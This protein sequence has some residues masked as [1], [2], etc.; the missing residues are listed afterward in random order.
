M[1]GRKER[2]IAVRYCSAEK[3][4]VSNIHRLDEQEEEGGMEPLP[5]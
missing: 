1:E 3:L 5:Q 4:Q 2:K